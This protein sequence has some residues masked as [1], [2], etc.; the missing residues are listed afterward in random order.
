MRESTKAALGGIVAAL[1]IVLMLLTYISPFLVYT[2]PAFAGLLLIVI[3]E[4]LGIRWAIGT[5]AA[6]SILSGFLIPDKEAA[7]FFI[8]FFGY[9]PIF[10]KWLHA[11]ITIKP[12]RAVIKIL[13]FETSLTAAVAVCAFV[14]HVDYSDI[15]DGGKVMLVIILLLLQVILFA[16]EYLIRGVFWFYGKRIRPKVRKIF[17]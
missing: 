7:V 15:T 5:Y 10:R 17:K 3:V 4:E 1:A 6:I 8:F 12:L 13:L 9:Y 16:Y 11:H 2:V 14:F